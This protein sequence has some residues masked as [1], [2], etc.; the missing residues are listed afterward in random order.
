MTMKT[1]IALFAILLLNGCST[2]P[3]RVPEMTTWPA[4][5]SGGI[6][7][8]GATDYAWTNY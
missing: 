4:N 6:M 5:A 2:T 7:K 1:L 3:V 8:T